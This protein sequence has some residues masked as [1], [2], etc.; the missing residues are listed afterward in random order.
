MHE[1]LDLNHSI[2]ERSGEE[3]GKGGVDGRE[4]KIGRREGEGTEEGEDEAKS[5]N[6][7][8]SCIFK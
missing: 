1:T 5:I 4:E 2:A 3:S 7:H 6:Q 8:D